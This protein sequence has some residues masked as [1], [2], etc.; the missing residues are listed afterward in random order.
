MFEK[1]DYASAATE[2]AALL[3]VYAKGKRVFNVIEAN[4]KEGWRRQIVTAGGRR[5]RGPGGKYLIERIEG[6]VEILREARD[7][8]IDKLKIERAAA[9]RARKAESLRR[10][11]AP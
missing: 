1:L 5:L 9:K 4:A 2:G 7:P 8:E 10:I 3:R 11:A 6:P